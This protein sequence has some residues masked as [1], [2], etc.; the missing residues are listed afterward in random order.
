MQN[1]PCHSVW[2]G[3]K[4]ARKRSEEVTKIKSCR[5]F[6][7]LK[8]PQGRFVVLRIIGGRILFLVMNKPPAFQFYPDD[9]LGGVSDMTQAEVGAYIL[10]LCHQWNC[11]K[12]SDDKSR[13]S[14]TAKGEV[15]DHVFNKFP[16]GKNKRLEK[17]RKKQRYYREK[18]RIN[19]AMGG[20]PAKPKP[21]PSLSFGLSQTEPKIT[22][23]SPSPSPLLPA[24]EQ[25]TISMA[26][27]WLIGA[28]KGGADYTEAEMKSAFLALSANGWMW[29]KNPVVDFRAALER[30]IQTDRNN[31][32][33][34]GKNNSKTNPRNAGTVGNAADIASQTAEFVKRQQPKQ[35]Q[36]NE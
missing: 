8:V 30:Q 24:G 35:E 21:N 19:G 14:L 7:S 5:Q 29:G 9:F 17:E 12:I 22:S 28:Q 13:L 16:S 25:P 18:Q 3:R 6:R 20:R 31:S 34:Y 4:T 15:S 2:P 11:G 36:A 10:L 23:P 1:C 27:G 32:K 26:T 33:S